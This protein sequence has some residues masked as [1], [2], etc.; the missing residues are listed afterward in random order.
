MNEKFILELMTA[1]D[2]SSIASFEICQNGTTLNMKKKDAP[3]HNAV[4]GVQAQNVQRT[5]SENKVEKDAEVSI[6]AK[7]ETSAVSIKSPIVGT[8]YRSPSPDA[9]SYA[10]VGSTVKKGQPL[11]ILEAMKMMNSLEAEFDCVI[12]KVLVSNGD[13]VEFDQP[14]FLVRAL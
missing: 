14:L 2:K 4:S 8:F 10:E 6:E 7:P 1:F 12:E 13:L 9:P 5:F 11:C 3:Q